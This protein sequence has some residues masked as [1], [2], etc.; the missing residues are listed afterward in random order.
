MSSSSSSAAALKPWLPSGNNNN[1]NN[2][3]NKECHKK[4][5][6]KE[7]RKNSKLMNNLYVYANTNNSNINTKINTDIMYTP[8]INYKYNDDYSFN[9]TPKKDID[10]YSE[11]SQNIYV[12]THIFILSA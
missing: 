9:I 6:D 5:N 7:K 4:P 2:N 12:D 8:T 10:I 11:I 1:N 3:N